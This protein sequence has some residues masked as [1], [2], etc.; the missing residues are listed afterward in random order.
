MRSHKQA[1]SSKIY[2]NSYS[3][4]KDPNAKSKSPIVDAPQMKSQPSL[5]GSN[6][7]SLKSTLK[8]LKKNLRAFKDQDGER[9]D[10]GNVTGSAADN[11]DNGESELKNFDGSVIGQDM[12]SGPLASSYYVTV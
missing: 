8:T 4:S 11:V 1:S 10:R 9:H 3:V 7:E 12:P 2:V 6:I 5:H